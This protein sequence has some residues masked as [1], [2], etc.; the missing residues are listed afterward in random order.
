MHVIIVGCGRAGTAL[1]TRLDAEGEGVCVVDVNASARE[2]LAPAFRGTFVRGSGLLRTV[3]VDAGVERA[4]AL[5][6]LTQSDSLN[7]VLARTARDVFH[8]PHSTGRLADVDHSILATDLGLDMV[9]TVRVITDRIYRQLRHR[10]LDP[11]YTF[12]NGESML[13]RAPAPTYLAGRSVGEFNVEGEIAV[14]EIT[15]G[16]HSL[17]PGA[18]TTVRAGDRLSFVVASG[19]MDRL[20]GFLGGR[21][22]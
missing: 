19:A 7:I 2:Q 9:T 16:G 18:G 6:A 13:V 21:W 22:D 17:V 12:G 10:V 3:L 1:A 5:V 11:E 4:D 14:V 15:R 20:K 8:V